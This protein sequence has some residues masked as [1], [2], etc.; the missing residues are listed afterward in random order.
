MKSGRTGSPPCDT[1]REGGGIDPRH[2]KYRTENEDKKNYQDNRLCKQIEKV[3]AFQFS[4]A[5]YDDRFC[6]LHVDSVKP[7]PDMSCLLVSVYPLNIDTD[8]DSILMFLNSVKTYLRN[9]VAIEIRRKRM[10]DFKF[11][12]V[13][14][15]DFYHP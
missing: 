5:S 11:R 10:P 14:N 15:P 6:G 12:I 8:P 4:G 7:E 9:E 13:A 2:V 1:L 3:L